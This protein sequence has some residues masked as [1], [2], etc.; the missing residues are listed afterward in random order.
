MATVKDWQPC[1]EADLE[2]LLSYGAEKRFRELPRLFSHLILLP[3]PLSRDDLDGWLQEHVAG[4]RLT[5]AEAIRILRSDIVFRGGESDDPACLVVEVSWSVDRSDVRRAR[6]RA[7]LL[8]KVVPRTIAVVAGQ[9]IADDAAA[10]AEREGVA[11][12]IELELDEAVA[13]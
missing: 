8:R 6:E 2:V 7:S 1:L 12:V 9:R 3:R 10:L 11:R 13:S 4:G 5:E